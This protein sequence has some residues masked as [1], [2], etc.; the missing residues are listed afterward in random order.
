VH[1]GRRSKQEP[2]GRFYLD[3]GRPPIQLLVVEFSFDFRSTPPKHRQRS[4]YPHRPKSDGRRSETNQS[5]IASM[6]LMYGVRKVVT[7]LVDNL[8]DF[9]VV[10]MDDTFPNGFF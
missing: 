9:L 3:T 10:V 1:P 2:V 7:K 6:R 5:A 8:A 4:G